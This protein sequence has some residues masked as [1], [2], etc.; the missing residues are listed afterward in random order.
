M[1][2]DQLG[3]DQ[4]RLQHRLVHREA[5]TVNNNQAGSGQRDLAGRRQ[6]KLGWS[7]EKTFQT[8]YEVRHRKV[9]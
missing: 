1:R 5:V 6:Q 7:V 2:V 3:G 4:H 8:R 9:T